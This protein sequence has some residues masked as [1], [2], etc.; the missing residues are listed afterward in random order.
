MH[1]FGVQENSIFKQISD[2][3]LQPSSHQLNWAVVRCIIGV[4]CSKSVWNPPKPPFSVTLRLKLSVSGAH[5]PTWSKVVDVQSEF[6]LYSVVETILIDA[7]LTYED[8]SKV[9]GKYRVVHQFPVLK[10]KRRGGD[11]T[12]DLHVAL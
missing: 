2:L 3:S 11:H 10:T 12:V 9:E 6:S 7:I 5:I 1:A 4:S 8:A